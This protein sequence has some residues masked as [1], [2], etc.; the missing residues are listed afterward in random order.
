MGTPSVVNK[1]IKKKKKNSILCC[2]ILC[3]ATHFFCVKKL[4]FCVISH[5]SLINFSKINLE[6]YGQWRRLSKI[7][8]CEK[9]KSQLEL[10]CFLKKNVSK[11]T[12]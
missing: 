1:A 4:S 5:N 8:G 9:I 7:F 2:D 12:K 6:H 3:V 10:V 11:S